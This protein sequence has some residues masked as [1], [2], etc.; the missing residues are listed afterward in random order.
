MALVG[1]LGLLPIN[2]S[3]AL[4]HPVSLLPYST[5]PWWSGVQP[6]AFHHVQSVRLVLEKSLVQH[7]IDCRSWH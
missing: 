5:E 2:P 7:V 1:G 4:L 3:G 6:I